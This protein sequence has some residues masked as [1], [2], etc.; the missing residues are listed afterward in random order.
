MFLRVFRPDKVIQIVQKL[1]K[2]E[3]ELGP[4]FIVPPP[5]DMD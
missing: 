3:K 5:F 4:P 1:V 2:K